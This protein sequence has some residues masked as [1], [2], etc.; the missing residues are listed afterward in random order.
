MNGG[1][2]GGSDSGRGGPG[3]GAG[4]GFDGLLAQLAAGSAGPAPAPTSASASATVSGSPPRS[5]SSP[6]APGPAAGP[7]A[8]ASA[9]GAPT[10]DPL[11]GL[12]PSAPVG[13]AAPGWYGKLPLLGDFAHRRLPQSVVDA[14][15]AWLSR[16]MA[17]SRAQLGDEWLDVY[18]TGPLWR[19]A[20]APGV[21]GPDWWFGVMMPSVDNVG[22][23]FPL[24]V[25]QGGASAPEGPAGVAG[26]DAWYA[27]V[28]AAVLGLLQ[29]GASLAG[30]EQALA[31]A[32]AWPVPVPARRPELARLPG[33]ERYVLDG[34]PGL[35]HWVAG[36]GQR[37]VAGLCAGRS[38]RWPDHARTPDTSLSVTTGLPEPAHF[39][40]LLEGEW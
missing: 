22:R 5:L 18:L 38:L 9:I 15:D 7:D 32:P 24:V 20:L 29:P 2:G 6:G 12:G 11:A 25:A 13:G 8:V 27:A 33:R 3:T 17:E 14:L 30:F 31:R 34:A 35:A 16:G 37:G 39:A 28:S 4:T 1:S 23:Y 19:F 36:L 40:L 26:L 21:V 10:F